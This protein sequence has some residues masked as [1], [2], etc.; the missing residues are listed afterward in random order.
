[1]RINGE[2]RQRD[3]SRNM[4]FSL[5][6]LLNFVDARV[7]LVPGDMVFTGSTSGVGL[8]DG[9]FL[10]PGDQL[11]AEIEKIG[12]LVHA[13]GPKRSLAP[14]RATGRLGLPLEQVPKS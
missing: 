1:M 7:R 6:E 9:R 8:E 4:I 5:D 10:Q 11:E 2:L 3:N 13:V 12:V 14:H